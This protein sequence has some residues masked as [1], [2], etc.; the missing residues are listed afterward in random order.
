MLAQD[1]PGSISWWTTVL[2]DVDFIGVNERE[3][4][5]IAADQ[6]CVLPLAY[7]NFL[8]VAG[9]RCGSLWL[10]SDAFYP[11]ILGLER[12]AE[13]LMRE[14][15]LPFRLHESDVVIAMHQGYQFLFL[16]GGTHNPPV[17]RFSEQE[18][19]AELVNEQFT[20]FVLGT[21]SGM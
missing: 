2:V 8:R 17:L 3:L 15:G 10:G 19:V 7:S 21:I 1:E 13:D 11:A 14:S 18:G 4:A 12:D 9:R 6:N 16:S 5:E 20:S